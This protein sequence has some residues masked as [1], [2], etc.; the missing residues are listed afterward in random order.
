M[1]AC[2]GNYHDMNMNKQTMKRMKSTQLRTTGYRLQTTDYK[3]V[4]RILHRIGSQNTFNPKHF[5]LA[6]ITEKEW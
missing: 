4:K 3:T 1:Y 6:A 5:P 2:I